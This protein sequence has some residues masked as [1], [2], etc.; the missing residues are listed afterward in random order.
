M[1]LDADIAAFVAETPASEFDA[2]DATHADDGAGDSAEA[3]TEGE[4]AEGA[5][6]AESAAAAGTDVDAAAV[7]AAIKAKDVQA[8][9]KALGPHADTLLGGKAHRALRIAAK[10]AE[11]AAEKAK[12]KDS[13]AHSLVQQLADKYGDPI[14]A[15]KA[16]EEGDVDS[17]I[18]LVEK[19]GGRPWNDLIRWTTQG[20]AGRKERLD[21]RDRESKAAEQMAA[22]K[23][24]QAQAEVKAWADAGVKKLAPELHDPEVVEM[25]VAEIRTG[26]S[27]GITTPAKALPLVRAKLQAR[28]ELL[29]RVFDGGRGAPAKKK[30]EAPAARVTRSDGGN[31][32]PMSLDESIA[33]FVKE[34]GL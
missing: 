7:T 19:W 18:T 25:V 3:P 21:A 31:T 9:L 15:R 12:K 26:F 5:E 2:L 34:N 28:Y 27:K 8:F 16:A 33:A 20:I 10:E 30:V 4:A 6:P 22:A 24:E 17:F 13:D 32:R 23:K 1:G 14:A 11:K 29:K